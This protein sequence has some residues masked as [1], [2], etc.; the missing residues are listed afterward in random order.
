MPAFVQSLAKSVDWGDYDVVGFTTTFEQQVASLAMARAIREGLAESLIVFG[1][2]SVAGDMGPEY[3]RAFPWVDAVVLGEGEEVF[4]SMIDTLETNSPKGS[5]SGSSVWP[6]PGMACRLNGKVEVG[7]PSRPVPLADI[8]DPEYGAYF[9]TLKRLGA[10]RVL[11]ER[12]TQ[13]PFE[14]S[15]GCWWGERQTCRF[16]GLNGTSVSFRR[17]PPE[18][19]RAEI[20]RLAQRHRMLDF[21]AVDRIL[22]LDAIETVFEPLSREQA[23]FSFFHQV[24]ASITPSDLIRLSAA[25]VTEVQPG[26]ESLSTRLLRLMHK[27][28]CL[29]ENLR[30]LGWARHLGIQVGWNLLSGFPGEAATDYSDQASLVPLLHHLQP[31]TACGRLWLERFSP[32]GAKTTGSSFQNR[33]PRAAYRFIYPEHSVDLEQ[34]AYF[35][36]FELE[37]AVPDP[38]LSML[39]QRVGEWQRLWQGPAQPW[40]ETKR[41]PGWTQIVD[42]RRPSSPR[43]Y[44]LEGKE[45]AFYSVCAEDFG[46]PRRL[47]ARGSAAGVAI[48]P[49]AA[50]EHLRHWCELG[51]AVEDGGRF[52]ALALPAARA[53]RPVVRDGKG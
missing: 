29:L 53:L 44:V 8:A 14:G 32:Y 47:A 48:D 39:H 1:G 4:L 40:L 30:C 19:L 43:E 45:A 27:G 38:D 20:I 26:I 15:R 31:P 11:G 46:S 33:R 5:G 28:T 25:G 6:L 2:A 51:I 36:D 9:D 22:D 34:I 3:L 13:I 52:L 42:G 17:K 12:R 35:W 37:G 18:R 49:Q 23:D 7:P 21:E 41:G 24:K 16:C 10:A 50:E